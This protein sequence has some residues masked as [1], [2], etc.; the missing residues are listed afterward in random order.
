VSRSNLTSDKI[1]TARTFSAPRDDYARWAVAQSQAAEELLVKLPDAS[2]QINKLVD[3]GCGQGT[4]T[5]RLSEKYPDAQIWGID[6]AEGM[7][8]QA[9]QS[10]PDKK[11]INWVTGDLEKFDGRDFSIV[12]SNYALQW[13]DSLQSV[14]DRVYDSLADGGIFALA[15]PIEGAFGEFYNAY[16]SAIGKEFEGVRLRH[17]K[18]YLA[19]ISAAG[20]TDC[21]SFKSE[22]RLEYRS[23]TE[24]LHSFRAIGATFQFHSEYRPLSITQMRRLLRTYRE[25]DSLPSGNVTL[26]HRWSIFIAQ[27]QPE[28][29][30]P[31]SSHLEEK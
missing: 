2:D 13:V 27:K 19:A 17:P 10:F 8:S 28:H 1:A 4:L 20:F 16:E 14:C 25:N 31:R 7:I 23:A 5:G 12:T 24:A 18:N 22:I 26:K 21:E 11:N 9:A 15:V 6:L 30:L 3:L 29:K